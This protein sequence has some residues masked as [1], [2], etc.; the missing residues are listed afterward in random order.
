MG[1]TVVEEVAGSV[2]VVEVAIAGRRNDEAA[3]DKQ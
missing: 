2:L 1:K 3:N